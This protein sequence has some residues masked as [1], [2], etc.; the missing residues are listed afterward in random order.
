MTDRDPNDPPRGPPEIPPPMLNYGT[1]K[2]PPTRGRPWGEMA[3]GFFAWLG[4]F[5]AVFA[6]A[7]TA[8]DPTT[9]LILIVVTFLALIALGIYLQAKRGWRGYFP[10]LFIGFAF[11]CLL[12]L[13]IAAVICG[14]GGF[15]GI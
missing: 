8:S 10:G 3:V 2:Y 4:G 15:K 13:G 6:L 9:V 5:A 14:T 11:T 1:R 7:Q 12:P